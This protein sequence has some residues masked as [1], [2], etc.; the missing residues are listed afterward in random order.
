[1]SSA[2]ARRSAFV[3]LRVRLI[4]ML[5]IAVFT[6]GMVNLIV[7]GRL[8][9]RSLIL[10]QSRRL[11]FA[12]GLLA[13]RAEEPILHDDRV[14]LYELLA[15]SV[16]LDRDLSYVVITNANGV[17]LVDTFPGT[18]PKWVLSSTLVAPDRERE[19]TFV[20]DDGRHFRELAEPVLDGSIGTVRV[21]LEETGVRREVVSLLSILAAMVAIFLISGIVATVWASRRITTPLNA[22]I[23][24]I[25]DFRL[26][27]ERV[28]LDISTHDEL[29][30]VAGQVE[31]MTARL[32]DLYSAE[33]A[34]ER[35][36]ARIERLAAVGTLAAGLAHELN[37]PLAGVKSAAQRLAKG[38]VDPARTRQYA[39]VIEEACRRMEKVLRGLLDFSRPRE[40]QPAPVA[41]TDC[42]RSAVEL[43]E[44]RVRPSCIRLNIQDDLPRVLA[45]PDLLVQVILNLLLNAADA[46]GVCNGMAECEAPKVR[47]EAEALVGSVRLRV[48][49]AGPGIAAEHREKIFDPFFTT[50][51]PGEGTGLGLPTSWSLMR[52][53]GGNLSLDTS[54]STGACF[55]IE[56]PIA[57][58]T[59]RTADA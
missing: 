53:M 58:S 7:L 52:E 12:A 2:Q 42:V 46:V 33:L 28:A 8:S 51:A 57:D 34:R 16:E 35:E 13:R 31:A 30:V 40:A 38:A 17:V 54:W 11:S 43:A 48:I 15:E 19:V 9:Y 20:T 22:I 23:R 39:E 55:I 32:Q 36:L 44:A 10:E 24:A 59:E 56:L 26:D 21:G 41:T 1:M 14:A 18:P 6:F 27:G 4:A 5:T 25:E 47:I 50:K 45:D 3:P 49:D 29:E 37:N